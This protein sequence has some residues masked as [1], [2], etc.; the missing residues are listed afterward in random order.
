[1]AWKF[2]ATPLSSITSMA[3][4][5]HG[6]SWSERLTLAELDHL[7]QVRT[8]RSSAR[9]ARRGVSRPD[10]AQSLRG[11]RRRRGPTPLWT[12][13]RASRQRRSSARLPRDGVLVLFVGVV[14][15]RVAAAVYYCRCACGRVASG[16]A[17]RLRCSTS[18]CADRMRRVVGQWGGAGGAALRI[19]LQI[20]RAPLP[21]KWARGDD[22]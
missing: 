20:Y 17:V 15:F 16:R 8:G 6:A 12:G 21:A 10:G 4:S 5:S 7:G 11:S 14:L 19:I 13:R 1:M 18:F 3:W 2:I 9:R 22:C